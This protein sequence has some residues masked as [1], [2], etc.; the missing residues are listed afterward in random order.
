MTARDAHQQ[1]KGHADQP[2]GHVCAPAEAL[3]QTADGRRCSGSATAAL[4]VRLTLGYRSL[5]VTLIGFALVTSSTLAINTLFVSI[6][7]LRFVKHGR[8]STLSGTLN[9][10]AYAGSAA[11]AAA[12]GFLSE[13]Y[14]RGANVA[15]WQISMAW[16]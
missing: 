14:G 16:A 9:A 11:A 1:R 3:G 12:I 4:A 5:V 13:R 8:A 10:V 15:S 2:G 7:P 6:L